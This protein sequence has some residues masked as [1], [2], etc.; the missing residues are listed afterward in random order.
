MRTLRKQTL[1]GTGGAQLTLF[2]A[3]SPASLS[4]QQAKE[5]ERQTTASS[6]RKCYALYE[7][8]SR[9][10]WWLRTLAGCLLS[11]RAWYSSACALTWKVKGTRYNRL[12]FRLAPSARRTAGT[13]SGLSP[14]LLKTPTAMDARSESLKKEQPRFG[15]SGTLAQEAQ[16]GFI[17]RR[18]LLPTPT[19]LM[20][21]DADLPRREARMEKLKAKG[22]S[23]VS[24]ALSVLA[25]KGLLPTPRASD[26]MNG[27]QVSQRSST[28]QGT[29]KLADFAASKLLPAPLASDCEGKCNQKSCLP[30]VSQAGG[31][32]RLNPLFVEEMMSFP[33]GWVASPFLSGDAKASGRSATP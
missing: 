21:H 17:Y 11:S 28:L 2:P 16:T 29:P 10:G 22:H 5:R 27:V 25:L 31:A 1:Q 19:A 33:R 13:G 30:S 23:P 15:S 14:M 32:S 18:G 6:G 8:C 12:L 3:D 7:R 26:C 24:D 20:A 4:A 9:H